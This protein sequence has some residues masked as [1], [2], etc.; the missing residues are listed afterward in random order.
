MVRLAFVLALLST[1]SLTAQQLPPGPGAD[2]LKSKCTICHESDIITSQKL[3]LTGWT[4]S[5]N[6][7]VRWGSQITPEERAVLQP[8]L[9]MHFAP[10]PAASHADTD[11]GLATY[12]RACLV[13]HDGDIISQQKLTKTGWTRSVEK[14]MRWGASVPDAEREP[15]IEY[16]AAQYRPR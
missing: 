15:L 2:V 1:A 13:C 6:K 14:M 11:A 12:K 16:L 3:S 8:Y 5:V 7:M 10:K 4:N 9:A